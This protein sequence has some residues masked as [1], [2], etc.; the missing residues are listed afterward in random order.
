M[1]CVNGWLICKQFEKKEVKSDVPVRFKT[2]SE[3]FGI[4]FTEV[5]LG[6]VNI[7]T[8]STIWLTNVE[9]HFQEFVFNGSPAIIVKDADVVIVKSPEMPPRQLPM[10]NN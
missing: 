4:R 6:N 3:D 5:L 9:R 10:V 2:R 8:G 7:Q 1:I